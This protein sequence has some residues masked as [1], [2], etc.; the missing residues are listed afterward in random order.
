MRP[1]A[2]LLACLA[3]LPALAEDT[4]PEPVKRPVMSVIV[5]EQTGLPLSY[6]GS[7]TASSEADL[8]FPLIG[9]IVERGVD[10]GDQ[11][12]EGDVLARID[13]EDLDADLRSAEA[14]VTIAEAQRQSASDARDR[15]A[16]LLAREVGS[17][18]R[19]EDAERTLVAAEAAVEQAKAALAR[20]T[21]LRNLA[22]L[23]APFD[24]VVTQIFAEPGATLSAGEPVLRLA[25]TGAREV[26]IDLSESDAAL[27]KPGT[28]FTVVLDANPD[29]TATAITDRI[30]PLAERTTR[31]RRVHLRLQDAAD[32]FR[33]GAL[34]HVVPELAADSGILLPAAAVLEPASVWVIDRTTDTVGLRQVTLGERVGTY[35]IVTDGLSPGDEVLTHG[36]HLVEDGQLVG[37][38]VSE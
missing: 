23:T 17:E 25:A 3:A 21:D 24:G 35:V 33:L 4:A 15:A 6:V 36:I 34:V 12:A 13:T 27:L 29:V 19:L 1:F 37:P 26:V 10:L 9:T 22:T 8:G 20:A 5:G 28:K 30:D 14:S 18:T 32:G 2:I 31:T 16:E 38:R 11:V 7:V